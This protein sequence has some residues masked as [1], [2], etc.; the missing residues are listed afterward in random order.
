LI[1]NLQPYAF[2]IRFRRV[3][4]GWR[5]NLALKLAGTPELTNDLGL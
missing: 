4:F 5:Q 2:A 1:F 3:V